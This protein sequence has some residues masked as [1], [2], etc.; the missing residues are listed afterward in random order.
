MRAARTTR[1][2]ASVAITPSTTRVTF[3]TRD[4]MRGRF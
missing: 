1:T 4:F 2:R 3:L